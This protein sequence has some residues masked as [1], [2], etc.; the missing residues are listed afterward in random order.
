MY[1]T[2]D[3]K[4][5]L[6]NKKKTLDFKLRK[7]FWRRKCYR[8]LAFCVNGG[9]TDY[10]FTF[11]MFIDFSNRV[12]SNNLLSDLNDFI[13][14]S[15][16]IND[17]DAEIFDENSKIYIP[18]LNDRSN[19]IFNE[20]ILCIC[21]KTGWLTKYLSESAKHAPTFMKLLLSKYCSNKILSA[22][23]NYMRLV[24]EQTGDDGSNTEERSVLYIIIPTLVS[25][26]S[27]S[28]R[29]PSTLI[30]AA[31]CLCSLVCKDTDKMNRI[32]LIQEHIVSKLAVYLDTYD[33]DDRLLIIS[34]ELF[35]FVMPEL[36]SKINEYLSD[37][38]LGVNVLNSFK[39]ILSRIKT[40]GA[41]Y[42]Q[43]VSFSSFIF[44]S[45]QK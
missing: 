25:I 1:E 18:S 36:K 6:E 3:P 14:Y 8:F 32:I 45:L 20:D 41:Y 4:Q 2:R 24:N 37:H 11:E 19:L 38:V 42:S 33:F 35:S 9:L 7:E 15:M 22:I 16:N 13:F 5:R 26:Y 23:Y 12:Q 30:L 40:P 31:K 27:D 43:R 10:M 28:R 29:C 17:I 21:I 44:R 34:L 39:N